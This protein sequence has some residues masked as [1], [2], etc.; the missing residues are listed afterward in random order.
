MM[1]RTFRTMSTQTLATRES[2]IGFPVSP[3]RGEFSGSRFQIGVR[4]V[5]PDRLRVGESG[6]GPS[7]GRFGGDHSRPGIV[8]PGLGI[9]VWGAARRGFPGLGL[10]E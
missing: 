7:P 3:F 9:G 5:R 8:V 2:G 6:K 4:T 10:C 1:G